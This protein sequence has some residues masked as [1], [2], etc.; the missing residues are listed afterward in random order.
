MKRR[1]LKVGESYCA[2]YIDP[3]GKPSYEGLFYYVGE[4]CCVSELGND[5]VNAA[6]FE[7]PIL[8]PKDQVTV[9]QGEITKTESSPLDWRID[10]DNIELID[11]PSPWLPDYT[12][13]KKF[14]EKNNLKVK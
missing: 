10:S 6:L 8:M 5:M 14:A 7:F 4:G 2:F 13:W 9:S 3:A 11:I 1:E 12:W